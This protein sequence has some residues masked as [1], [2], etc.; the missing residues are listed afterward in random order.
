VPSNKQFFGGTSCSGG[1]GVRTRQ[2]ARAPVRPVHRPC[3]GARGARVLRDGTRAAD[4]HPGADGSPRAHRG[5]E[6]ERATAGA[7]GRAAEAIRRAAYGAAGGDTPGRAP[8][9]G[10]VAGSAGG[11]GRGPGKREYAGALPGPG[12]QRARCRSTQD[13]HSPTAGKPDCRPSTRRGP[14]LADKT[15]NCASPASRPSESGAAS[16]VRPVDPAPVS[17]PP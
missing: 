9:A 4:T 7:P 14:A 10:G 12:G 6:C 16:R 1:A 11:R 5:A 17:G 15:T 3:G 2:C 8:P 13:E